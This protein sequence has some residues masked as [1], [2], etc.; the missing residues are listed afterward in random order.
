[1]EWN[2]RRRAANAARRLTL[3]PGDV[4]TADVTAYAIDI[5]SHP[6]SGDMPICGATVSSVEWGGDGPGYS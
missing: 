4:A 2:E 5:V 6:M 3:G 1:M